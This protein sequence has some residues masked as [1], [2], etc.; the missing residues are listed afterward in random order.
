M[1]CRIW[2][3]WGV[4]ILNLFFRKY[5]IGYWYHDPVRDVQSVGYVSNTL[6]KIAP[7]GMPTQNFLNLLSVQRLNDDKGIEEVSRFEIFQDNLVKHYSHCF[8][9]DGKMIYPSKESAE[10]LF[11]LLIDGM[12]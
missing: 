7:G 4:E 9:T 10:E 12:S 2:G 8:D 5:F 6:K 1:S 11:S 3:A